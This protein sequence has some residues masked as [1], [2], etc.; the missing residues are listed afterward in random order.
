MTTLL[1]PR[2]KSLDFISEEDT[3]K[4]IHSRLREKYDQ[5][6]WNIKKPKSS[7]MEDEITSYFL[8]P[9]ARKNKNPL[10]WW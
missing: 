4:R 10:D 6:K 3:K 7:V 1:D 2:Y 8:M 5:L 9:T